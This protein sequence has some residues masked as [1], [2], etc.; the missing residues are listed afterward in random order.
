MKLKGIAVIGLILC[1]TVGWNPPAQAQFAVIDI[2]AVTQLLIEVRQL[3]QA[4]QLAQSTLA[5]SQQAYA[6]ITGG[7]GMQSL[8]S[9]TN[10]N[11]LP[12]NWTQ[13][14]EAQNGAGSTYGVLGND[15]TATIQRNA[16]LT[17]AITGNFSAAENAQLT[18]RRSSVA[19]EEALTRQE[20]ANVS[21]RFAAVQTL[22]NAIPTA[23]DQK[24]ILD[25][26]ARIQVEQGMLQN[27]NSKLHVLY[28]AA[29][30]QAQTERARADE[31]AILDIG[32]LRTLPPMGLR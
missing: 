28:E 18:A 10:R 1:V 31:Q 25:L 5:Q 17:P 22:T 4:V 8:L 32:H 23:T 9:G 30:S 7:R 11:Y 13:L 27:E 6:A 14:V 12:G 2:G 26:Q 3:E 15:V 16:I 19:L 20:L 21:Q 24:A 29:Q